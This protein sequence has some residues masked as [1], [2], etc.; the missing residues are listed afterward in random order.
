M[1]EGQEKKEPEADSTVRLLVTPLLL[2]KVDVQ[3]S[4]SSI[5]LLLFPSA[6]IS[7]VT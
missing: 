3:L 5:N 2:C 1:S 7:D 4:S 6:V